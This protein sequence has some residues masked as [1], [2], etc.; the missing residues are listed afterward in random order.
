MITMNPIH[1][2][3][4]FAA[5]AALTLPASAAAKDNALTLYGGYRDGDGFTDA[6]TDASLDLEAGG[7][8]SVALDIGL[9][10]ARQLQFLFSYQRTKMKLDEGASAAGGKLAM[11]IIYLHVGGT[12]FFSEGIGAGPYVV[13][14]IGATLFNP[15]AGY[16]SE[17]RPSLNLGLGYQLPLGDSFALRFEARGYVTLV[18]SSGG[19]FCSGGCVVTIKGDAVFQGEVML[20]VSARF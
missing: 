5:A 14:G 20:G 15:D 9:D 13:G 1:A 17:V 12:N 3:R 7:T 10:G 8:G 11:D 6:N 4:I 16:S 19:L 18:N 2:L